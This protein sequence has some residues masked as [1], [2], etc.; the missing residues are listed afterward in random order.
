MYKILREGGRDMLSYQL[1]QSDYLMK[2]KSK[3]K[4]NAI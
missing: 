1:T 4:R 3:E 2:K